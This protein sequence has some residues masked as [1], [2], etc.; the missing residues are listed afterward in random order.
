VEALWRSGPGTLYFAIGSHYKVVGITILG[1]D[2]RGVLIR[3]RDLIELV[4]HFV[5]A[6]AEPGS[7]WIDAFR[8]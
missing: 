2:L 6:A 3:E 5:R 8:R 1:E 4:R 7:P